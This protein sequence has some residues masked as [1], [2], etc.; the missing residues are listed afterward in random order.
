[1]RCISINLEIAIA[2]V[3]LEIREHSETEGSNVKNK[4]LEKAMIVQLQWPQVLKWK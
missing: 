3:T 2:N 1:M 4:P